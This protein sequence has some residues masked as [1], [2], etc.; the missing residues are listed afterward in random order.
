MIS[1][2]VPFRTR[3]LGDN[4]ATI[5]LRG[6]RRAGDARNTRRQRPTLLGLHT[7]RVDDIVASYH[8][9]HD[10]ETFSDVFFTQS[11]PGYLHRRVQDCLAGKEV[12]SGLNISFNQQ[13]AK[14]SGLRLTEMREMTRPFLLGGNTQSTLE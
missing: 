4:L 5:E 10:P 14:F 6:K 7:K 2:L 9:T 11:N 12:F 3:T 8:P 13:F 1:A